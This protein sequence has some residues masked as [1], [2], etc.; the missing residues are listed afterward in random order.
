ML[1]NRG[2]ES[3]GSSLIAH[4]PKTIYGSSHLAQVMLYGLS[5]LP[6]VPLAPTRALGAMHLGSRLI[7]LLYLVAVS[8]WARKLEPGTTRLLFLVVGMFLTPV[9]VYFTGYEEV[10]FYSLPF[11][12]LGMSIATG[13]QRLGRWRYLG[14]ATAGIGAALHGLGFFFLPAFLSLPRARTRGALRDSLVENVYS[15]LAFFAPNGVAFLAYFL[16]MKDVT[17]VPGDARGGENG[18]LLLQWTFRRDGHY[19]LQTA[20]AVHVLEIVALTAP[21]FVVAAL[22]FA[23]GPSPRLAPFRAERWLSSF[24][25]LGA[26]GAAFGALFNANPWF[27]PTY[28]FDLYAPALAPLQ[29]ASAAYVFT[30]NGGLVAKVAVVVVSIVITV[31]FHRWIATTNLG[32]PGLLDGIQLIWFPVTRPME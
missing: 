17:I 24:A 27:G 13:S 18:S 28:D 12:L 10:G 4:T 11:V 26:F 3:W 30:K 9:T 25:I 23:S 20:H 21:A 19:F 6:L 16:R 15:V 5:R 31:V 29:L 7:G 32:I 2:D 22:A 8:S 1:P 14:A